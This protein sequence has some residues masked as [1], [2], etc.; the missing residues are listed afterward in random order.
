M[1]VK[2][3]ELYVRRSVEVAKGKNTADIPRFP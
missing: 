2:C 1:A 3:A